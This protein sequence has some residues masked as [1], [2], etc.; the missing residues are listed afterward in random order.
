MHMYGEVPKDSLAPCSPPCLSRS[1]CCSP[2]TSVHI[3]LA[4]PLLSHAYLLPTG[5]Q[6]RQS[7]DA[8]ASLPQVLENSV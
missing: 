3:R 1:L 4:C 7:W 6:A 2:L 8:I 5:A